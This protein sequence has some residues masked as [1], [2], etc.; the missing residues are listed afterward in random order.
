MVRKT[1]CEEWLALG[2]SLRLTLTIR[3]PT[4][5]PHSADF[6]MANGLQPALRAHTVHG[7]FLR[8]R[9]G[10]AFGPADDV[11]ARCSQE[12][13]PRLA[14]TQRNDRL[15]SPLG[16]A[17][18]RRRGMERGHDGPPKPTRPPS[19]KSEGRQ[20]DRAIWRFNRLLA[21]LGQTIGDSP[22]GNPDPTSFADRGSTAAYCS[23]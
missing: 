22:L 13:A 2:S 14:R 17:P 12:L 9:E 11:H 18:G 21:Q 4:L 20:E 1:A 8:P 7:A 15:L 10:Y 19:P 23:N 16:L 6:A 5:L 3:V